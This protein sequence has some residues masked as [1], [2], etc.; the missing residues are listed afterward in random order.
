MYEEP[1]NASFF[2]RLQQLKIR[3]RRAF[4]GSR[5]GTHRS[6]RKG[7]GLEFSDFRAYSPG[8]DF[9]HIDWNVLART[10]RAYVREYREE[11]DLNVVVLVDASASMAHPETEGKFTMA[12]DLAL[13]L[14]YVALTDGDTVSFSLLG[15]RSSPRFT[16]PRALLR[17]QQYLRSA[18]PSGSFVLL[19][20][21]RAAIA[22]QRIPGK[23]F[24]VSDFLM[25][26]EE[27]VETFDFLRSRNFE[28]VALQVLAP[29]ELRLEFDPNELLL[30][31][32]TGE[33]FE[34]AIDSSST[35]EYAL[36]LSKHIEAIEQY[37][38][39]AN[40]T[41]FL[42]S[43]EQDCAELVLTKFPEVGILR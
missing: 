18:E 43:S 24:L 5:Q 37:C 14:G 26:L 9:R 16:G 33:E 12:R 1:F 25:D 28:I 34:L 15:Q 36:M 21:V 6:I 31:A 13:A 19:D 39:G 35:K 29:S 7:H 4:L 23:C 42:A 30:D 17:A 2:K 22:H 3:T 27:I 38:K 10:D 11:Q 41:H 20:E 8:D 32:E 40:I